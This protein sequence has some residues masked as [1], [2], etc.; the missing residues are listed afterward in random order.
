MLYITEN[1]GEYELM[2]EVWQDYVLWAGISTALVLTA[3]GISIGVALL[4]G[5][6][7]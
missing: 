6:V 5:K 1:V 3:V 2:F 4:F 7:I